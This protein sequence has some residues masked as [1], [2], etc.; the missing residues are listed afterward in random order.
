[1]FTV[2]KKK[3]KDPPKTREAHGQPKRANPASKDAENCLLSMEIERAPPQPVMMEHIGCE[4][5][6]Y[7]H[8]PVDYPLAFNFSFSYSFQQHGSTSS[9][10]KNTNLATR[11][12]W[13]A[14]TSGQFRSNKCKLVMSRNKLNSKEVE[15]TTLDDSPI[16]NHCF[17]LKHDN[18]L[19]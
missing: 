13:D 6:N 9:A 14:S 19:I 12:L 17:N 5:L 8:L 11:M 1:M 3:M 15:A 7:Q 4:A 10:L 18:T 16:C 2:T